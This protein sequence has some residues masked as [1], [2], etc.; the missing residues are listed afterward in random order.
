MQI[1]AASRC[2]LS[3]TVVYVLPSSGNLNQ[4]KVSAIQLKESILK[5]VGV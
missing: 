2:H 5:V 3:V 1:L 4:N